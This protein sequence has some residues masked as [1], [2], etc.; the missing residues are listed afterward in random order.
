MY[1]FP[2]IDCFGLKKKQKQQTGRFLNI[3][4]KHTILKAPFT[5]LPLLTN[6]VKGTRILQHECPLF[7]LTFSVANAI[8]EKPCKNDNLY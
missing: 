1:N 8:E 6:L 3:H 2:K 4:Q 7:H 5:I